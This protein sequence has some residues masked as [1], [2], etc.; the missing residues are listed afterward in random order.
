MRRHSR[1]KKF[2]CA[3]RQYSS[4]PSPSPSMAAYSALTSLKAT[5]CELTILVINEGW[6]R[7]INDDFKV[8]CHGDGFTVVFVSR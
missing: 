2:Q 5:I 7:M 3:L 1:E 6:L 4:E 8:F